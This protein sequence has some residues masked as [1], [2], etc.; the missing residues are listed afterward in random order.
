M[1]GE[2]PA[3]ARPDLAERK[4]DLVV[5]DEHAIK[6][7]AIGPARRADRTARLIHVGE[8][9]EKGD[10]RAPLAS[11]PF[12]QPPEKLLTRIT[13]RPTCCK[14]LNDCEADVMSRTVVTAP[15]VAETDNKPLHD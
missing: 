8:R 9:L 4:V 11:S 12:T 3:D 7:E 1:T 13:D 5:N 14:A 2:S 6:L 10:P 15:R